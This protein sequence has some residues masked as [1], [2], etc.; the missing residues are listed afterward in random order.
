MSLRKLWLLVIYSFIVISILTLLLVLLELMRK[1]TLNG[2]F[3][4]NDGE[5]S[6]YDYRENINLFNCKR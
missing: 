3:I 2:D 1:I 4:D 6:Y 5:Y